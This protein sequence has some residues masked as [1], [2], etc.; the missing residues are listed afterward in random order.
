MSVKS[1]TR[2]LVRIGGDCVTYVTG[3]DGQS[4]AYGKGPRSL[5]NHNEPSET[6]LE[7]WWW[8][9]LFSL[10]IFLNVSIAQYLHF[11]FTSSIA[12][13]TK[14]AGMF[15][16]YKPTKMKRLLHE[17][18]VQD[19]GKEIAIEESDN[20]VNDPE[21]KISL[22]DV[23]IGSIR[24]LLT[25]AAIGGRYKQHAPFTW[26]FLNTFSASP[27]QWPTVLLQPPIQI[28]K[29]AVTWI[30]LQNYPTRS[31]SGLQL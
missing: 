24:S 19:C 4:W 21:L 8:I 20:I 14:R 31:R 30:F 10:L 13:V 28:T 1:F 11:I 26:G 9:L 5:S 17:H 27:N 7:I 29:M 6:S 3:S 25:P 12:A 18:I 2:H 22:K 15:M 23:T 16:G